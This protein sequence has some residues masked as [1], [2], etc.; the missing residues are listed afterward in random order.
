MT[1]AAL[2]HMA[3]TLSTLS[4][5]RVAA[6][7]DAALNGFIDDTSDARIGRYLDVAASTL[8]PATWR[9]ASCRRCRIRHRGA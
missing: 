4:A 7:S 6:H 9:P 8:P 5:G 1:R 2:C 3:L